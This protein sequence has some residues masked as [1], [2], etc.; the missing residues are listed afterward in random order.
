VL[1]GNLRFGIRIYAWELN[2]SL[3]K[4][5]GVLDADFVDEKVLDVQS[6]TYKQATRLRVSPNRVTVCLGRN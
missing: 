5:A 6:A 2:A 3:L 4:Q 1:S